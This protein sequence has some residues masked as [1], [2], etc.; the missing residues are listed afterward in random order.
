MAR[1]KMIDVESAAPELKEIFDR[2]KQRGTVLNIYRIMAW[3]PVLSKVWS[4]CASG[5]RMQ[6]SV[7]RRMRELLIVQ[8]A[9]RRK[10]T[11]EYGHHSHMALAEGVTPAQLAALPDWKAS[12]LFGAD[13]ALILQL[14]DD[15]GTSNGASATTMQALVRRFGEK[16]TMELL[17]TG[18]FYCAVALIVNSVDV[19]LEA[20]AAH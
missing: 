19:E 6:L 20:E 15:L 14:A 5:L 11:Y 17:A 3:S 4:A 2:M 13:D 8:I 16:H 9:C 18:A 10:S 7:S 1:V 12:G